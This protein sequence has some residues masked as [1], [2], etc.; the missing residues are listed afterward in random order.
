MAGVKR[1]SVTDRRT[2]SP[3]GGRHCWVF[4]LSPPSA[5]H[6]PR[7]G[8]TSS[9]AADY[10]PRTGPWK[11]PATQDVAPPDSTFHPLSRECFRCL[12]PDPLTSSHSGSPR[13]PLRRP[14]SQDLVLPFQGRERSGRSGLD[15]HRPT[16]STL[17]KHR[18]ELC[19]ATYIRVLFSKYL[20]YWKCSFLVIFLNFL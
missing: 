17:E 1:A 13:C 18:L 6:R 9:R 8:E 12:S 3:T 2:R 19:R 16:P 14:G 5:F 15:D 4:C 10:T 20:N 7:R 11:V